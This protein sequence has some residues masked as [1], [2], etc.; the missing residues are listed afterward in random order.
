MAVT[1]GKNGGNPPDGTAVGDATH[2]LGNTGTMLG[3]NG[4]F[5][6]GT[7]HAVSGDPCG[8]HVPVAVSHAEEDVRQTTTDMNSASRRFIDSSTAPSA[9]SPST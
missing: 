4:L 8:R 9:K 2:G 1:S 3:E 6:E 7:E 5:S